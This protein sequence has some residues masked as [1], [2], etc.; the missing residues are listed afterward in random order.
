M[1]LK[2][3]K[4]TNLKFVFCSFLIMLLSCT[5]ITPHENFKEHMADSV[6][7][8]L[9]SAN[10]SKAYI[11]PTTVRSVLNGN[12]ENEYKWRGTCRYFIEFDPRTRIIVRWRFTGSEED[13]TVVP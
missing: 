3:M 11:K 7:R 9:D 4:N 5:T 6:G 1:T 8:S 10:W 2:A 13:C 12:V